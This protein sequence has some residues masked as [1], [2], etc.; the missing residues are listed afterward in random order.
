MHKRQLNLEGYF[1][2]HCFAKS[3]AAEKLTLNEG[4]RLCFETVFSPTLHAPRRELITLAAVAVDG[5][6]E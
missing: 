5:I 4:T 3:P 1:R 6:G 2:N